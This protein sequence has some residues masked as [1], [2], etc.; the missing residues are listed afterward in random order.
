MMPGGLIQ[1]TCQAGRYLSFPERGCRAVLAT[2]S[3]NSWGNHLTTLGRDDYLQV[4]V[5][6]PDVNITRSRTGVT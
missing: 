5:A 6:S 4:M 1:G 3:S 2:L